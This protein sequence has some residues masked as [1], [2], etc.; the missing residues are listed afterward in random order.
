MTEPIVRGV[1]GMGRG[2]ERKAWSIT[3]TNKM[4]SHVYL[5]NRTRQ[6]DTDPP[7]HG[8]STFFKGTPNIPHA[9]SFIPPLDSYHLTRRLTNSSTLGG[10]TGC[11]NTVSWNEIGTH[12]LSGSDDCHLNIYDPSKRKVIITILIDNYNINDNN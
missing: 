11:V 1:A 12:L 4:S 10:H 6:L 9:V 5:W 2:C 3:T 7:P 8:P